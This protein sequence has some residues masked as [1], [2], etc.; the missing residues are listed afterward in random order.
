MLR[1][2][3]QSLCFMSALVAGTDALAQDSAQRFEDFNRWSL[4]YSPQSQ[5][6][7]QITVELDDQTQILAV[8]PEHRKQGASFD[9]FGLFNV[10]I[11]GHFVE[12]ALDDLS[13][14]AR[15]K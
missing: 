3:L 10:Q 4:R 11:G 5:G 7:G 12:I 13:Y 2:G 14:T 9:R 6:G 8:S 1:P 15:R